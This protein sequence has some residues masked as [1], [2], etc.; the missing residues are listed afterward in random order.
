ML[1]TAKFSSKADVLLSASPQSFCPLSHLHSPHNRFLQWPHQASNCIRHGGRDRKYWLYLSL[2][3]QGHC[4]LTR[5][6]TKERGWCQNTGW[7]G[8]RNGTPPLPLTQADGLDSISAKTGKLLS[9]WSPLSVSMQMWRG[10]GQGR[11][12]ALGTLSGGEV[13]CRH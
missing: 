6:G 9:G 4:F 11:N 1:L 10:W 13:C 8:A 2:A 3:Y 12:L 7:A 5:P